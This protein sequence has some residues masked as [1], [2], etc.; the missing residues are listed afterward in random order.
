MLP[1]RKLHNILCLQVDPSPGTNTLSPDPAERPLE[2]TS[3]TAEPSHPSTSRLPSTS[4]DEE[5]P[6]AKQ[7]RQEQGMLAWSLRTSQFC[8]YQGKGM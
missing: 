1:R 5:E 3:S 6:I 7:S 2:P 4:L 8:F